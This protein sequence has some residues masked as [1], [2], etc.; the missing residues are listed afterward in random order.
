MGAL[1][2][3]VHAPQAAPLEASA[4]CIELH[5]RVPPASDSF[6]PAAPLAGAFAGFE[7]SST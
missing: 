7:T 2:A 3:C 4:W 6:E 5:A 1:Q